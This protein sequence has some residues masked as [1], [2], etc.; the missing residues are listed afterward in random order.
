M[1]FLRNWAIE[2]ANT[3]ADCWNQTSYQKTAMNS[4]SVSYNSVSETKFQRLR[5]ASCPISALR[6]WMSIPVFKSCKRRRKW[7]T[8]G[9]FIHRTLWQVAPTLQWLIRWCIRVM[10]LR[11]VSH[12]NINKTQHSVCPSEFGLFLIWN[13]P[14]TCIPA[15]H[16]DCWHLTFTR[17]PIRLFVKLSPLSH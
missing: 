2:I 4:V 16:S 13:P 9:K 12:K 17:S 11:P 1:N 5:G 10:L 8:F 7:C 14:E 15:W 6:R 3:F